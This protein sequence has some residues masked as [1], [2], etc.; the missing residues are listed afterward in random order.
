LSAATLSP[1]DLADPGLASVTGRNGS[2]P[3]T[4][5]GSHMSIKFADTQLMMLSAAAM[6]QDRCLAPAQSLRGAQIRKTG[7][8][9]IEAGIVR[10]VKAKPSS[11]VWRR[12]DETGSSFALKLTAAGA[13]AIAIEGGEGRRDPAPE[14]FLTS[15]SPKPQPDPTASSP[16]GRT[17]DEETASHR[18][19]RVPP[20]AE[21]RPG[22][23]IAA[24]IGMLARERGATIGE[25]VTATGWLP[26]TTRAALT[27]LRKRGCVLS[28]DRSNGE[29]GSIYRIATQPEATVSA[30]EDLASEAA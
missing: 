14:G 22:S 1:G 20:K 25:L 27:G 19:V 6:R 8:K 12:D 3:T 4:R 18:I 24:V 21:P 29:R 7:E 5:K 26:H 30:T 16:D 2:G 17:S 10:E 11:P 9:L 23:K 13:K 15:A 28:I